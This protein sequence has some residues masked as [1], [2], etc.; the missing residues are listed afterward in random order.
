MV[1][2]HASHISTEFI[3]FCNE[4]KIIPLCLP[5]HTTHL[6]Q[7]LD[8]SVFGPLSREYK[9][10]LEA[11]TRFNVCSIDK[12]DFLK[13]IQKARKE[14]INTK[15]VLTAWRVTGL[16]PYNPSL[17]LQ[18]LSNK[19]SVLRK[20]D[21]IITTTIT[22][23]T[24]TT[25]STFT[26][27]GIDPETTSVSDPDTPIIQSSQKAVIEV[28]KTP[29]NIDQLD[30]L[31]RR[32]RSDENSDSTPARA[33]NKLIKG[34]KYAFADSTLLRITNNEL[35]QA[36]LRR[37]HRANRNG[38]HYGG[39]ARVLSLE[40]VQ[41]RQQWAKTQQKVKD[42]KKK[43]AQL[44]R[45]EQDLIKTFREMCRFGPDLLG[46]TLWKDELGGVR[47]PL[48]LGVQENKQTREEQNNRIRTIARLV[49]VCLVPRASCL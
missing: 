39:K 26:N 30:Q 16:V 35:L 36:N 42:D 21:S 1:D 23:T 25:T 20:T 33:L 8:V 24:T 45:A 7:P 37:H 19:Q 18:K 11:V 34:A 49:S 17:V 41:Q 15:N 6:L 22:T 28:E 43:A 48:L 27:V 46:Q 38:A 47:G 32:I 4:K 9:K 31:I 2:G 5:P 10:Q 44:K 3:K 13:I 14:A 12:V 29:A 40:D